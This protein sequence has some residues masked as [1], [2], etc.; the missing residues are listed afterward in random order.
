MPSAGTLLVS[1]QAVTMETALYR[2]EIIED[3]PRCK[4]NYVGGTYPFLLSL[5]EGVLKY[6]GMPP[7]RKSS[8][9]SGVAN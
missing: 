5:I 1:G 2:N 8:N 7:S 9:Q 6:P 3:L 4:Q